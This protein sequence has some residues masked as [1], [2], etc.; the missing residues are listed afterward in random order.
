MERLAHYVYL[1]KYTHLVHISFRI[2]NIVN[3]L[4]QTFVFLKDMLFRNDSGFELHN[5]LA[6]NV[7]FSFNI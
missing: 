7:Q 2:T 4:S 5:N 1:L 3:F 6:I